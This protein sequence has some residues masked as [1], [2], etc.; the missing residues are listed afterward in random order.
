MGLLLHDSQY[1]VV[2]VRGL[3][4]SSSSVS[5]GKLVRL[6][7]ELTILVPPELQGT[8]SQYVFSLW[9]TEFQLATDLGNLQ[10]TAF[11][12]ENFPGRILVSFS[13][14]VALPGLALRP[15]RRD[16]V[17]WRMG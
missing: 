5:G 14:Y 13:T 15:S 16:R 8:L 1:R 9:T 6:W 7:T 17:H 12:V 3:N 10:A 2:N 11:S 4:S